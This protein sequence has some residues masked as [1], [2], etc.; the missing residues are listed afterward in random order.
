MVFGIGRK[1]LSYIFRPYSLY[2]YIKKKKILNRFKNNFL[3]LGD[4]VTISNSE[5]GKYVFLNNSVKIYNSK[6]GD[7]SYVNA[8]TIINDT[9]IGKFCSIASNVKFGLGWHPTDLIS[10]HPSFY[11]NEHVFKT[12]AKKTYFNKTQKIV[13]EDDVWIGEDAIIMGGVNIACGAIVAA[14]AIVTKDVSPYEVVGGIPAKHIK[15]RFSSLEIEK[16]LEFK[17][18]DK[19][20][21][22]LEENFEYFLNKDDFFDL[23]QKKIL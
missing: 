23:I 8:N 17:W 21:L 9:N 15:F 14:G 20:E 3:L 11:S 6:I 16:L 19:D 1:V 5:I 4:N 12:Y 2:L 13:I 22:W 18:W 10:T 7:H